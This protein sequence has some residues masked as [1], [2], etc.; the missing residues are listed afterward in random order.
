VTSASA[1]SGRALYH[2]LK[3]GTQRALDPVVGRVLIG[4]HPNVLT[5]LGVL[6]AAAAGG[7]L[8]RGWYLAALPCIVLRMLLNVAD[9]Q[10]ARRTGKTSRAGAVWNEF[11]DRLAD[12]GLF[13]GAALAAPA[14]LALGL[15]TLAS[16][17][18][19]SYMGI[20]PQTLGLAR[21]YGGASAKIPRQIAL[22]IAAA[23]QGIWGGPWLR[24]GLIVIALGAL[25]TVGQRLRG[26]FREARA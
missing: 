16:V 8:W 18:L 6:S 11:S 26:A 25:V 14:G 15:V 4:V 1:P 23:G 3:A 12:I 17:G 24:V 19:V 21:Q 22:M 2:Y 13:G 10:V 7:C 9:G 5:G 20:L